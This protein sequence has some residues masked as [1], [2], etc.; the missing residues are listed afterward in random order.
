MKWLIE[1]RARCASYFSRKGRCTMAADVRVDAAALR[2]EVRSKYREVAI[3][4]H[5]KY[6]FHTGRPLAARLG[7][8][9]A[10]V[11]A[12]PDAAVESFAGVANPFSFGRLQPRAQ[13][14]YIGSGGGFDCVIAAGQV[15]PEGRVIGVDM[16]DEM[17]EKA[18]ATAASMGLSNVEF[19]KGII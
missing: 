16:T 18:R 7:Y 1:G 4:P 6:H 9:I 15:G 17:L 11:D 19:R 8:D 3:D 10:T 13:V 5:G 14:I 12:L 2:E